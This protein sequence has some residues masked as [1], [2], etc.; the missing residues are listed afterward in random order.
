MT[1]K[2]PE[3]GFLYPSLV[4]KSNNETMKRYENYECCKTD[5]REPPFIRDL[6]FK[7]TV[8][9]AIVTSSIGVLLCGL[10][11]IGL[12]IPLWLTILKRKTTSSTP[13]SSPSQCP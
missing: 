4:S 1:C 9:P 7:T 8:Y 3:K 6:A 13:L 5:R 12:L 2:E 11:I 10:L